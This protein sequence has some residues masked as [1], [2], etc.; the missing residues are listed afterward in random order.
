MVILFKK[1]CPETRSN[2]GFKTNYEKQQVKIGFWILTI[3]TKTA[4]TKQPYEKMSR[5]HLV[6]D[7]YSKKY[8]SKRKQPKD[9]HL[10]S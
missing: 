3:Y 1:R 10:L 7:I 5:I 8:S 9:I 2:L 4:F 6:R